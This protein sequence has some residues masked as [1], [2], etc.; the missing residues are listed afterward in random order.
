MK[1]TFTNATRYAFVH[2]I[3]AENGAIA[4]LDAFDSTGKLIARAESGSL[5]LGQNQ[6][7]EILA[8]SESIAYVVAYGHRNTTIKI[9]QIRFGLPS[10]VSTQRDGSYVF[11]GV[12]PSNI[13][14]RIAPPNPSFSNTIPS[15]GLTSITVPASGSLRSDF[16]LLFVVSP[17]QNQTRR[18]DVNNDGQVDLFDVLVLINEI[19]RNGIRELKST[20]ATPPPFIDV[21]G[22]RIVAPTDAL[23]VINLVNTQNNG[24]QG[25]GEA[26]WSTDWFVSG[27]ES[28]GWDANVN[29]DLYTRHRRR[30]IS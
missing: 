1:A 28:I 15:N 2:V 12:S 11:P 4:R 24:S 3:G 16:G 17:W 27:S 21:D 18:Q 26:S 29:E 19:N 8:D 20:D 6:G 9:D 10:E 5:E 30:R 14:V 13:N 23:I 25:E 7:L 22:D